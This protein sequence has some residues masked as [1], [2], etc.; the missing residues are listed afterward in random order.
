MLLLNEILDSVSKSEKENVI[1]NSDKP[2]G[3][4]SITIWTSCEEPGCNST[5]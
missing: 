2:I 1:L 3:T 4:E 5:F